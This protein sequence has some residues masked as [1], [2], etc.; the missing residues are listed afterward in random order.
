LGKN[1]EE[2]V[3]WTNYLEDY[4]QLDKN[5]K[6]F[7]KHMEVDIMVP[8]VNNKALM[9]GKLYHTGEVMI[10]H[11]ANIFSK[12][13]T[14]QAIKICDHRLKAA[15]ER[16]QQ[17]KEEN[18]LYRNKLEMPFEQSA[19]AN[20]NEQDIIETYDEEKERLW[21][22]KHRASLRKFKKQ[23]ARER[24][25][26]A[27]ADAVDSVFSVLDE[28][29]MLEELDNEL[30]KLE[31]N[32]DG[33]LMDEK[34]DI[35][36]RPRL[37]H[38]SNKNGEVQFN[39][40]KPSAAYEPKPTPASPPVTATEAKKDYNSAASNYF[41]HTECINLEELTKN[42]TTQQKIK[43]FQSRLEEV[44]QQIGSH[45]MS[46][47]NAVESLQIR[48]N[49]DELKEYLEDHIE[50]LRAP[51]D[52]EDDY[53]SLDSEPEMERRTSVSFSNNNS[54][55]LMDTTDKPIELLTQ[56]TLQ[57]KFRHSAQQP[58]S[59]NTDD[60]I[61]R[62]PADIY[63]KFAH[64]LKTNGRKSILKNKEKVNEETIDRHHPDPQEYRQMSKTA[65]AM[66]VHEAVVGI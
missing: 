23:E 33:L 21:K 58:A 17:L 5:M 7:Q 4:T 9:P 55:Q 62:S 56:K 26:N 43:V 6:E 54:I 44:E 11:G 52:S 12:C 46:K 10:S 20:A 39:V 66:E 32:D 25:Q 45:V 49:L 31:V 35:V 24:S 16:L 8:V 29:E 50:L 1:Q 63:L 41:V 61:I 53:K 38:L 60:S 27:K 37:S 19:F 40:T 13:T 64:C 36:D 15:K 57:L 48:A 14:Y 2:T 22:E 30:E 51:A 59:P 65:K 47:E 28:L 18:E 42:C 34:K 3:K